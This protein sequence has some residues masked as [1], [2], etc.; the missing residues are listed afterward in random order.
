MIDGGLY[1]LPFRTNDWVIYYNKKV[2]DDAGVAY[3]TN[4]YDMGAV[5]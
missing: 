1:A 5:L 2:F 3:P 4:D